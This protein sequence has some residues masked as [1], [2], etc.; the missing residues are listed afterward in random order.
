MALSTVNLGDTIQAADI[1]QL[2]QALTGVA[3]HGVAIIVTQVDDDGNYALDLRQLDATNGYILRL[4]DHNNNNVIVATKDA[5][6]IAKALTVSAGA[7]VTGDVTLNDSIIASDAIGCTV[8]RNSTQEIANATWDAVEYNAE[9]EDTDSCW[10]AGT[11]SRL[12]A[13]HAG[14]YLVSAGATI[15]RGATEQKRYYIGVQRNGSDWIKQALF[16]SNAAAATVTMSIAALVKM[17]VDDYVEVMVQHNSGAAQ[18]IS[19]A[20]TSNLHLNSAAF[21]RIA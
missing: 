10:A 2:V 8:Y 5:V 19:A 9:I 15:A 16:E 18:D 7:T 21:Y 11:P 13:K 12:V 4:R 14:I 6:T 17:A 20:D 1:N 3:G